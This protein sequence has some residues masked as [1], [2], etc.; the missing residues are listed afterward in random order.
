MVED[1]IVPSLG[2]IYYVEEKREHITFSGRE[3]LLLHEEQIYSPNKYFWNYKDDIKAANDLLLKGDKEAL[4]NLCDNQ[5]ER[6]SK[7][8][9]NNNV[10]M[11]SSI[12]NIPDATLTRM[13]QQLFL[14]GMRL[15][16]QEN[17]NPKLTKKEEEL[18]RKSEELRKKEEAAKE[19]TIFGTFCLCT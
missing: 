10:P 8:W 11:M 1:Q 19:P 18:A 9:N 5:V 7:I 12:K 3:D 16:W 2:M 4:Q 14:A 6:V 13:A 17:K 15:R